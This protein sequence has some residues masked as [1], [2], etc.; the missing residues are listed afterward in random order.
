MVG[1]RNAGDL[2][3]ETL[4]GQPN[5][6]TE[7][8][9]ASSTKLNGEPTPYGQG[10]SSDHVP[11]AEA[12]VPDSIFIHDPTEPW[13]DTPE[14]TIDKISKEELQDVAEIVGTAVYDQSRFDNMG[15]NP[16]KTNKVKA[17][18]QFYHEQNIR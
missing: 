6:V 13:Y 18:N 15:P 16:K 17:D 3:M 4:D 10:G 2:V 7:L 12:G 1:S 8:A 14:D 11:F 5:F 9:Q